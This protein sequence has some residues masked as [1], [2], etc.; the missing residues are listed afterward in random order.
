MP[1]SAPLVASG[2]LEPPRA[3]AGLIRGV[4]NV[5]PEQDEADAGRDHEQPLARLVPPGAG[6]NPVSGNPASV[7]HSC[8]K[9]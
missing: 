7:H 3:L 2:I 9:R 1:K 4:A 6:G 8:P 5:E